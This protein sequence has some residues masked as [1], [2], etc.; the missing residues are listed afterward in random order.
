MILP[1]FLRGVALLAGAVS[2]A[3]PAFAASVERAQEVEARAVWLK[4]QRLIDGALAISVAHFSVSAWARRYPVPARDLGADCAVYIVDHLLA[5]GE[6][7]GELPAAPPVQQTP[8]PPSSTL[9]R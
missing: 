8:P 6:N 9:V 3:G 2:S 1:D 4:R 5:S 7:R